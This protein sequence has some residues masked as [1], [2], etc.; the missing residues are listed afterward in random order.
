M[1]ELIE[2]IIVAIGFFCVLMFMALLILAMFKAWGKTEPKAVQEINRKRM[3]YT[4][5]DLPD[6][7]AVRKQLIDNGFQESE[8]SVR[9]KSGKNIVCMD[10]VNGVKLFALVSEEMYF[11]SLK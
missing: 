7:W 1:G 3:F 10:E 11:E 5:N 4:C 9:P 6:Y 8:S 2:A